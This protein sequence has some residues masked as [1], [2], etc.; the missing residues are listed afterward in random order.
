[1]VRCTNRSVIVGVTAAF[2]VL[3][4]GCLCSEQRK[5]RVRSPDNL[6]VATYYERSCGATAADVARVDIARR[7]TF[8]RPTTVF[9]AEAAWLSLEWR[10]RSEL[11]IRTRGETKIM[12]SRSLPSVRVLINPPG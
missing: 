8:I 2:L 3:A 12:E 4:F 5:Q 10:S 7:H 9:V 6:W 1:V 11:V